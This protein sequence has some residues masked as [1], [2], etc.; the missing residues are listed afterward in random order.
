LAYRKP[1]AI[2]KGSRDYKDTEKKKKLWEDKAKELDMTGKYQILDHT[3]PVDRGCL[4]PL[5][6]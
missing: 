5:G 3:K 1:H 6:T 4:L 2:H